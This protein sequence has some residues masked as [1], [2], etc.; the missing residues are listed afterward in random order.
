MGNATRWNSQLTMI[1]SLLLVSD[2]NMQMLDYDGKL[3]VH[4]INVTKDIFL[5][6]TPFKTATDLTKVKIK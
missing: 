3:N 5:I 2:S 6:L 1:K 4:E